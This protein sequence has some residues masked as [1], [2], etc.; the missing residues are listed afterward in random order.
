MGLSLLFITLC[1]DIL[2]PFDLSGDPWIRLLVLTDGYASYYF[3]LINV[4]VLISLWL[5]CDSK[6]VCIGMDLLDVFSKD[7]REVAGSWCHYRLALDTRCDVSRS[8]KGIDGHNPFVTQ[9]D[10]GRSNTEKVRG[11]TLKNCRSALD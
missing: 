6:Y 9:K 11:R 3:V 1:S 10:I 2:S 8:I 5:Q 4:T 7:Y